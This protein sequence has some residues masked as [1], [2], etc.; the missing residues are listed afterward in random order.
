MSRF[1]SGDPWR[2]LW[3]V[4]TSD[5]VLGTVLL[6]L[7]LAL[8]LATWLPQMP[9]EGAGKAAWEA[10]VFRRFGG[11]GW[12]DA[13]RSALQA[14]GAFRVADTI[15]LRSLLALLALSLLARLFDSAEGL[16]RGWRDDAPP[17]DAPWA[18]VTG[19]WD[20]LVASLRRQRF[21][22]VAKGG[23]ADVALADRWPW[24]ELGPVLVYLGGLVVLAGMAATALWGWCAGPFVVAAGESVSLGHESNLVLQLEELT[25]DG[26]R[27]AGK[28][29]REGETLVGA[30]DMSV[31]RPLTGGGVGVYLVGSGAGL[32]LQAKLNSTQVLELV[33]GSD[34]EG[35]E[36]LVLT[37]TED[38]ARRWVSVP[39]VGLVLFL[40]MPQ[41]VQR[42]TLP[43]VQALELGSGQFILE[44]DAPA[45]ATLAIGDVSFDLT[46]VPCV[47]I[48]VV[49][50]PGAFWS[51]LGV[52]G[53]LVGVLLWGLWPPRRL[54]LRRLAGGDKSP[55][56]IE[57]VGDV[58]GSGLDV[59]VE[60]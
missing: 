57:V 26:Q 17:H 50:D 38:D 20:E 2:A 44:P 32:R 53:L 27:G 33:T 16:W 15:G 51:Q 8:I 4:A 52:A 40:T 9:A 28:V 43:W 7:A 47:Q 19:D 12:S 29:W 55:G 37:F 3:Q 14:V 48:Q 45:D 49:H 39:E 56:D 23:Q 59:Q 30:G 36:E 46:P 5:Y 42:G 21:R 25:Q 54:W 22:I 31:G 10:E 35:Q 18:R 1:R 6:A 58:R 24:G 41:P 11:R 34:Q 13:M 60:G